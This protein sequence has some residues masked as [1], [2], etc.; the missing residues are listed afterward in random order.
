MH[1]LFLKPGFTLVLRVIVLLQHSISTNLKLVDSHPNIIL[2][3][4]LGIHLPLNYDKWPRPW[5]R[6]ASPNYDVSSTITLQMGWCF[7]VGKQCTFCI[8]QSAD[9]S[10]QTIQL[11][12]SVHKT[13][14]SIVA[15]Q[16]A[17]LFIF[18]ESSSFLHGVLP[19]ILYLFKDLYMVVDS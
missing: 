3:V 19:C 11:F 5:G 13:F 4:N 10:S 12:S 6:Q 9:Y 17:L 18:L 14:S 1:F 8:I 7:D 16:G 15:C 2:Y